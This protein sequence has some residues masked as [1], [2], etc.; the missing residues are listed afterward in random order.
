MSRRVQY[1]RRYGRVIF[2]RPETCT[3]SFDFEE[4]ALLAG[5]TAV[6]DGEVIDPGSGRASELIAQRSRCVEVRNET[7]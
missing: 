6:I 1:S 2:V 7:E 3:W 4:R 5:Y